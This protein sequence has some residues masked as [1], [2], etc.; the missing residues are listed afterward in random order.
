MISLYT[1]TPGSGKSLHVAQKL[2]WRMRTSRPS[3]CNFVVQAPRKAKNPAFTYC[4]NSDLTP[5]YL[6]RHSRALFPEGNP[7]EGSILLVIDE[8]QLIFNSRDWQHADR[9]SWISF[10]T[11]HRKFGYDII[12]VTQ[13]DIMMD[14]QV[15]S[16]VEYEYKHRK[17]AN[18][19]WR[20]WFLSALMFTPHMF[21]A[22]KM[23]YGMKERLGAEF[24]RY[25][26]TYGAIYDTYTDF[27]LPDKKSKKIP[28]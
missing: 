9:A 10:F 17:V 7:K 23:W 5:D 24:F 22:V 11:Q 4:D 19:G 1:G 16:I 3:V 21:V 18:M 13:V 6:I 14:K 8:A 25:N 20:G 28:T 26:R 15:R 2:Y 27:T 12:L